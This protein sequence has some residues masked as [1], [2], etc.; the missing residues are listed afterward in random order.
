M[1]DRLTPAQRHY[2]MSRIRSANTRPELKLRHA[3]WDKGFRYRIN[4]K[5]LPGKPDIVFPKYK[6]IIF[7]HGCFWHGHTGCKRFVVPQ[8]NTEFW[9]S[10]INRNKDRDQ[11]VWRKL[12]SLGWNV[13]IVWECQLTKETFNDSVS[14]ITD[15]LNSNL[16]TLLLHKVER[17]EARTA[18]LEERKRRQFISEAVKAELNK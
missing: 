1:S 13:I 8:T 9:T 5:N 4:D 16:S 15:E 14:R 17:K 10:K 2:N 3:L 18:Y 12:E 7:V 11:E 6:T